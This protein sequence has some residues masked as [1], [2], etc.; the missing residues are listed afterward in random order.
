MKNLR[1]RLLFYRHT[2]E[3]AHEMCATAHGEVPN[4]EIAALQRQYCARLH[5]ALL[6]TGI[7]VVYISEID[8]SRDVQLQDTAPCDKSWCPTRSGSHI[9][10][11]LAKTRISLDVQSVMPRKHIY[12]GITRINGKY[13]IHASERRYGPF[14][15]AVPSSWDLLHQRSSVRTIGPR[16]GRQLAI[17][18]LPCS[19]C[20]LVSPVQSPS[21]QGISL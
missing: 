17:A 3:D 7:Q 12:T 14:D 15:V 18:Q 4:C 2:Y 6:G 1:L 16:A 5:F 13:S 21:L 11:S 8:T 10:T 19:S 20:S 9:Q